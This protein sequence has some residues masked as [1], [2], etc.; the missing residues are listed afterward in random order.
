[1]SPRETN[2]LFGAFDGTKETLYVKVVDKDVSQ[3]TVFEGFLSAGLVMNCRH[4]R[5]TL[6]LSCHVQFS[7]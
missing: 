1:M 6:M 4:Q 3:D 7:F 2:R 5:Y